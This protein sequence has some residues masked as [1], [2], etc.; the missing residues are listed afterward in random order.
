STAISPSTGTS[1]GRF[2]GPARF[3]D[4]FSAPIRPFWT[5]SGCHRHQLA[6]GHPEVRQR[7][8]RCQ[9]CG[10]LR[11]PAVASLRETELTLYHPK[12]MLHLRSHA[13]L[14][15]FNLVDEGIDP[16][17]QIELAPLARTHRDMPVL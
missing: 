13:R 11:Q 17:A 7:E 8:Q 1:G 3:A 12:R 2:G 14:D 4:G 9:L 16:I 15:S 10:V 6:P 5:D